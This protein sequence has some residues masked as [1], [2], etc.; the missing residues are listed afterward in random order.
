L[1][2]SEKRLSDEEMLEKL[3]HETP[4]GDMHCDGLCEDECAYLKNCYLGQC[5]R[6]LRARREEKIALNKRRLRFANDTR[7]KGSPLLTE[8]PGGDR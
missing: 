3:G 4:V 6:E 2:V 1:T 8:L 7:P 5:I